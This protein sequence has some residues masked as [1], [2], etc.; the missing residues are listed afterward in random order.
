MR[1]VNRKCLR[2]LKEKYKS[3]GIFCRADY[4]TVTDVSESSNISNFRLKQFQVTHQNI[5]NAAWNSNLAVRNRCCNVLTVRSPRMNRADHEK[6][7]DD[8]RN[9]ILDMN[10]VLLHTSPIWYRYFNRTDWTYY[11]STK[12]DD[13]SKFRI[14]WVKLEETGVE[15]FV[16]TQRA[17]PDPVRKMHSGKSKY[18]V[19]VS[20]LSNNNA[21]S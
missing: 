20:N 4:L 5:N 21:I 17:T 8:G 2:V 7:C 3:S 13:L 9:P 1:I 19:S 16:S 18:G 6:P 14:G 12:F 11:R 10:R 15:S